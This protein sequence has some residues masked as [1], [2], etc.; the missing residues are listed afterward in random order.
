VNLKKVEAKEAYMKA[1]DKTD[2]LNQLKRDGHSTAF[3]DD[4]K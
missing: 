4:V 2:I 3:L 1:L